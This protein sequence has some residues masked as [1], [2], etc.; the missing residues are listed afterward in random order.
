MSYIEAVEQ[1]EKYIVVKGNLND[2]F[3]FIGPF[4]SFEQADEYTTN[5]SADIWISQLE[6]P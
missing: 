5:D 3:R 4:D 2:G 1:N 6:Q